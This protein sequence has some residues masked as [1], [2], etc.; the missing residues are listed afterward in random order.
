MPPLKLCKISRQFRGESVQDID[1]SLRGEPALRELTVKRGARL[2]VA[3]GSR[4][5]ANLARIVKSTVEILREKGAEPFIVPA[6]G[7]HGGATAE[8]QTAL[9]ASLG[10][11]ESSVSG[12]IRSSME[13]APLGQGGCG[14][15]LCMDQNAFQSDGI[16][17]INRIKPHTDFHGQYESGL[18]KMAVIGL[19][20]ERQAQA[21]HRYGVPGLRDLVPRA[22]TDVFGTGKILLGLAIVENASDET[23]RIVALP[24]PEILSREPE[25]LELARANLPRLPVEKLDVLIVDRLGKNISGT[26][27]DTNVIGRIRIHGEPEPISPQIGAIVVTDLTEESHGNATGVGL[28]DV[29]TRRLFNKIDFHVTNRNVVT[30][31]FLERGKI[32]LVAGTDAEAVE[33]ALRS[34]GGAV[35]AQPRVLRIRDTL[36]LGQLYASDALL[37]ELSRRTEIHILGPAVEA[38]DENG[39]LREF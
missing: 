6:M 17:L 27:M 26:G 24:G 13:V 38:F 8:G 20:K 1:G 2:A 5:I 32:P 28:A 12:P 23:M 18:V 10:I 21:I 39:C 36:H 14:I 11:T 35:G 22:A 29:T 7:S 4:G 9:L 33:F 25:L 37:E 16:V 15:E 19:G 31:S 34:I 3:V 30:S